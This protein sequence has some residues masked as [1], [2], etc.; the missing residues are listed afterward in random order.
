MERT[1]TC[2]ELRE[3]H[4]GGQVVLMGWVAKKRDFGVF[5]F[6]DLRDRE[7]VTQI[8]LS[9]ETA[10]E[11]HAKAKNIRGEFVIAVKGE[12]V[13]RAEGTHNAKLSTGDIEVKAAELLILN[14]AKVPPFQLEVAGSEN[15]ASE[16]TRLKYRYL[17][18]R[19]PQ[20][21]NNIR[22]RAKA[23][24]AIREYFDDRGF[25]EIETPILLKS[26]PEGARDFVVPSR[27]HTGKFFA[28][29]Q[30][31]QILKQITMIAGFD[32]YY[33]IARCFRDEDLRADRQPEFT[34]LDMEMSFVN[35]EQ[36]YREMEGMFGHV[37]KLIGVDLPT[38]WPRMTYAE[39]MRRYGSDKPDL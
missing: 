32:K 37:F 9:S 28:L 27:I 8:V 21:Q 12:V 34:Q 4:V 5:T 33:Q 26:T 2:G 15:L 18:L 3:S 25:T 7:G 11:A 36:V 23:V 30:S 13:S 35:R 24:R 17:D 14:D 31:P 22:M 20:L 19:R 38:E 16:D 1:H 29:P 39:A 10:T 6:I